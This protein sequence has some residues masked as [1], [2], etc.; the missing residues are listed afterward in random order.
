YLLIGFSQGVAVGAGVVVAQYLG[1]KDRVDTQLAVHTALAI[2]VV[3]GL[4]LTIGGVACGRVLLEWMNTPAEVLEDAVTYIRIYFGGVLF[5]VV[6]NM[7]AGILNAAG[8]SRRSLVYLA[9]ASLTNIL[10]DLVFI[11][12]LKMGVAGAAIATDISQLVS[13]LLS[14]RFLLRVE[15]DY[16]VRL[17]DIRLHGRMALRI[18]RVGLPTGIQ[19]MVISFSNVLV[20]ASVNSYGAAA[21]AGFAAYM[22]VDGFNILP[23]SSISMAATTFVGQN[24]G[25]GRLDRVR[26]SVWVTVA[27]GVCYT[28]TTGALLLLGQDPIM[29]LFTTDEAVIAFGCSAMRWF[30]PFYFLLSILHGLAGAVRGTGASVPPMVVLLVSLCLFRILW[31]QWILPLFGTYEGVMMVYP[32]SWALGAVLMILYTWKGRWMEYH[33]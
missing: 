10:L 31:I 19:N 27:L 1:A 11:V 2:S 33:T 20:Q 14:L 25:A 8:N 7:I 28:L 3:M 9:Y 29:R 15:D 4:I 22:K 24:Y 23:V 6:Y 17:R 26:K 13:C 21:M 16:R 18:I 5:S 30:C 12:G 32:V